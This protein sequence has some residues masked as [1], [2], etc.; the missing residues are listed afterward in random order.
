MITCLQLVLAT[1][2]FRLISRFVSCQNIEMKCWNSECSEN[3]EW[4]LEREFDVP[5]CLIQRPKLLQ[6]GIGNVFHS[7]GAPLRYL[8]MLNCLYNVV[9]E[10]SESRSRVSTQLETDRLQ[11]EKCYSIYIS[12]RKFATCRSCVATGNPSSS[13]WLLRSHLY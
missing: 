3:A 2:F 8:A 13:P 9:R 10:L 12:G 1:V 5:S 11:A 4:K 6:R 7:G